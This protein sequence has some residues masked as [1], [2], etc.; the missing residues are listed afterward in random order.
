VQGELEVAARAAMLARLAGDLKVM[1][2]AWEYRW[3]CC[4]QS[5]DMPW[6]PVPGRTVGWA[7]RFC[8]GGMPGHLSKPCEHWHHDHEP[9]LMAL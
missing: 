6:P 7:W 1:S 8:N 9:P 5:F 4:W 2:E 3:A